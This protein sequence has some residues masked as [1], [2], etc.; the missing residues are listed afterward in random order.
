MKN[1]KFMILIFQNE[2]HFRVYDDSSE[3]PR[4]EIIKVNKRNI[5][6]MK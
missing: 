2:V 4:E 1:D 6:H 5:L 3:F